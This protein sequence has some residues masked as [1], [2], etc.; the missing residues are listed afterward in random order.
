MF[1]R[2]AN[3]FVVCPGGFGTLDE[4]F[5]SLV[6]I[7]TGKIKHFPVVLLGSEYW[8]GLVDWIREHMLGRGLISE[9]DLGLITVTDEPAEAAEICSRAA[10][11]QLGTST[12]SG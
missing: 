2:Y 9:H 7:Q 8:S 4:M 11:R 3:A 10:D 6:L 1:V 12:A 5:E